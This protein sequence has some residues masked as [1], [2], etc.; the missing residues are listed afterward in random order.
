MDYI[1][2]PLELMD[3]RIERQI[4][5]ID[6]N[7]KYP[8]FYCGRK[9]EVD[10]MISISVDPSSPLGCGMSDCTKLNQP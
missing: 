4:D 3:L 2:D 7:G 9:F 1:P 5:L 6:E 10:E 8:C